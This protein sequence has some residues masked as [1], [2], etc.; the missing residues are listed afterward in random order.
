PSCR[1]IL[2]T[3]FSQSSDAHETAYCIMIIKLFIINELC[4]LN[5]LDHR[6]NNAI[7]TV[8]AAVLGLHPRQPRP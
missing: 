2:W 8:T 1:G 7:F 3:I 6:I 5:Q 4:G